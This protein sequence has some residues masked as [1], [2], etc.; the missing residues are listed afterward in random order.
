MCQA[1]Q[2]SLII[3][4]NPQLVDTSTHMSGSTMW[5]GSREQEQDGLEKITY[6]QL[7]LSEM[8]FGMW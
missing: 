1:A 4:P 5:Q 2:N 8:D 7:R 3:T 6:H